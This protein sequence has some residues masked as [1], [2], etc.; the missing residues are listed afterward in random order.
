MKRS[1]IA[2]LG[3]ALVSGAVTTASAASADWKLALQA[4]TF[5]KDTFCE[6]VD[7]TKALGLKYIEAFPG[8]VIGE[9]C[10]AK[11]TPDVDA[12]TQK[13]VLAKLKSAGVTLVNF[14]VTGAKDEAGWTKLFEFAKAMGIQTIV[15]EPAP[16]QMPLIDKLANK[17]KINVAIHNHPEPSK[18]WNPET[19]LAALKGCSKRIGA[20]A[21][22]GHWVRSGLCP[23]ASL[24]KLQGHIISLHLKDLGAKERKA[25]D[26]PW[27]TGVG[28]AGA[29]LAEM[30]RQGFKGVFSIEYEHTTPQLM[31]DVKKCVCYF[32][33]AA[34]LSEKDLLAGK[35]LPGG[36]TWKPEDI[37]AGVKPDAAGKWSDAMMQIATAPP[38]VAAPAPE[39][40]TKREM[41]KEKKDKK[42]K[43]KDKN[44]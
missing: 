33:Q 28:N 23:I 14:G 15:S 7:R 12:A 3:V 43:K 34:P 5:N 13:K 11:L 36:F 26:V 25:H 24:R 20:C 40:K 21:D 42:G 41:K 1:L 18:Y 6:T 38:P 16:E 30:K 32:N 39:Q 2:L 35:A 9:G 22:T 10:E 8:Q 27:G 17:Y 19:V 44:K 31:C 37:W 4:W 29:M